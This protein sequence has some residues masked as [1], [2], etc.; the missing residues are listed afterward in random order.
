MQ[1]SCMIIGTSK[2]ANTQKICLLPSNALS[3][4]SFDLLIETRDDK[5]TFYHENST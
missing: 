2:E 5:I 1:C 3:K 4:Q